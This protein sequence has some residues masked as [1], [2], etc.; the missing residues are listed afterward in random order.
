MKWID[1]CLNSLIQSEYSTNVI[2]VDN[3]S[4]DG[5]AEK[6]EREFPECELIKKTENLGF[7]KANNIGIKKA[8]AAG[9]EYIFLL[10]HDAWVKNDTIQT[11]VR[12]AKKHQ[13]CGILSPMHL[14][15]SGS[16]LDFLFSTYI[17]AGQCPGL[18]SDLYLR[19][20]KE[21]YPI[22]NV[23]AA[24]WL[25]HRN[26]FLQIGLFDPL[27]H[28]YGEDNNFVNRVH[29]FGYELGVT[30]KAS[31]YHDREYRSNKLKDENRSYQDQKR[32]ML[33]IALNPNQTPIQRIFTL[34]RKI[35]SDVM[36][37]LQ[38]LRIGIALRNITVFFQGIFY[39]FK[40]RNR[41][42][43]VKK[44]LQLAIG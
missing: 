23:N 34:F 10:N 3:N 33:V 17:Q 4:T 1:S 5:T 7:A 11:L 27:F 12:I 41:H 21:Y 44:E 2:I 26:L 43:I 18:L 28:V 36:R 6:I 42:L 32:R 19:Q 15:G 39:S 25:V 37:N 8:L 31:I 14:N 30:P 20:E 24:A 13:K 35:M 29:H 40:Y 9:A 38:S 22:D 16:K